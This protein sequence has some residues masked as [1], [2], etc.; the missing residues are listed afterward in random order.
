MQQGQ[1]DE[2]KALATVI[3]GWGTMSQSKSKLVIKGPRPRN[4]MDER[5]A[6]VIWEL[7]R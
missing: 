7:L 3:F 4:H 2:G 6:L 5:A 1:R